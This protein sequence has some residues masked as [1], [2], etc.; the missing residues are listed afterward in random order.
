MRFS[1]IVICYAHRIP[2]NA[3]SGEPEIKKNLR[4]MM[5][6]IEFIIHNSLI[7]ARGNQITN[8]IQ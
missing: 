7:N 3:E 1:A 5:N 8:N 6:P 2:Q 4:R